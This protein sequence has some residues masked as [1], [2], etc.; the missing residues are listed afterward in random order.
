MSDKWNEL[1]KHLEK[2]SSHWA[3]TRD[4]G[5]ELLDELDRINK[6]REAVELAHI[7]QQRAIERLQQTHQAI[8]LTTSEPGTFDMTKHALQDAER[9][10]RGE[11]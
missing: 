4:E 11:E 10:L 5:L 7:R 9:I 1:R 2:D 3:V 8:Q 6:E